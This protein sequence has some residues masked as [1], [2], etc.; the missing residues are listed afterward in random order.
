MTLDEKIGWVLMEMK[1]DGN[2]A[3]YRVLKEAQARINELEKNKQT[4]IV[5]MLE[6]LNI[7]E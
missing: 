4:S 5:E 1:S 7:K 3:H 6:K 2:L